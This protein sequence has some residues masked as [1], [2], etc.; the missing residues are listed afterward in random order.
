MVVYKVFLN[1]WSYWLRSLGEVSKG[2]AALM[3]PSLVVGQGLVPVCAFTPPSASAT[4]LSPSP[5][6][7]RGLHPPNMGQGAEQ[8][9]APRP[10]APWFATTMV[11]D[12]F[13]LKAEKFRYIM[14]PCWA[15]NR[16]AP[17]SVISS[18]TLLT[19]R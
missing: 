4:L 8:E 5:R 17:S 12:G 6:A 3:H 16:P 1:I 19:K 9:L 10:Q 18:L 14:A 7:G 13:L 2:I 15:G 11:S